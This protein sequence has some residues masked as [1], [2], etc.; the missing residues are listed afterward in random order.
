MLKNIANETILIFFLGVVFFLEEIFKILFY[1]TIIN[2]LFSCEF[3]LQIW[4]KNLQETNMF[5]VEFYAKFG[6]Q[7]ILSLFG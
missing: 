4:T 5:H 6:S 3:F 2:F 7:L 1:S